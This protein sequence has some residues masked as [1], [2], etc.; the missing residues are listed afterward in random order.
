ME[1]L[2]THSIKLFKILAQLLGYKKKKRKKLN[3]LFS[4][5]QSRLTYI[6]GALSNF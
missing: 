1:N 5:N 6:K 4:K 3:N 2:N